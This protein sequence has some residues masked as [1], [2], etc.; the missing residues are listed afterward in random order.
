MFYRTSE[1]SPFTIDPVKALICPRPIGWI[2]SLS[3]SGVANLAP[4]SFFNLVSSEPP[5]IMFSSSNRKDSLANIEA[6][7][8]FVCNIVGDSLKEAMIKT[9]LV[10]GPEVDEFELVLVVL[11]CISE[12][13]PGGQQLA[14]K[15]LRQ[16]F[17][18][19]VLLVWVSCPAKNS[20]YCC[21]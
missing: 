11:D 10:V 3:L 9:S 16:A 19:Q 12:V 15:R 1:K 6:T 4:Y 8:E 17:L 21:A 14:A 13:V 18:D 7:G 20:R 5:M 2:S